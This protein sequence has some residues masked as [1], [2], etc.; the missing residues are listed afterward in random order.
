M[1]SK[2]LLRSA[3]HRG[4]PARSP[5]AAQAITGNLDV[6]RGTRST[7]RLHPPLSG[8]TG[9]PHCFCNNVLQNHR[10]GKSHRADDHSRFV[11]VTNRS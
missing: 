2:V 7:G 11:T 1:P 9:E 10:G 6:P 4:A 5:G 3:R 8:I